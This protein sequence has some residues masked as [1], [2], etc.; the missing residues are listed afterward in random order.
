M[1]EGQTSRMRRVMTWH[2]V[3]AI[4]ACST[5]RVGPVTAETLDTA[6]AANRLQSASNE[7]SSHEAA[8]S[9]GALENASALGR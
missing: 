2:V 8:L 4:C 7:R 9:A 5:A 6:K 1:L 3:S